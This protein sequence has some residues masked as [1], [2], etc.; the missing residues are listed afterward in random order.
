MDADRVTT[1]IS[2]LTAE[3]DQLIAEAAEIQATNYKLFVAIKDLLEAKINNRSPAE[4]SALCDR[5]RKLTDQAEG[6]LP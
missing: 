4:I 6:L 1:E 5:L 3:R 2:R